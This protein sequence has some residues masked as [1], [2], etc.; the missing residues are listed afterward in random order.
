M[1]L[2]PWIDNAPR[3]ARGREVQPVTR[4]WDGRAIARI[5]LATGEDLDRAIEGAERAF[6]VMRAMPAHRRREILLAT[7]ALLRRE[8]VPLGRLMAQDAGKPVTLA[9]AE[10]DRAIATFTIAGEELRHGSGE[11]HPADIDPRGEGFVAVSQRFPVG[12]I[13]AISPFNFPLNLVAHKVAPAIAVGSAL[14]LK[15]PPQAPLVPFRLAALLAEAGLPPGGFQVLHL[16]IAVAERL[17]TDPGFAML[18]FTGSDRVGWHLKSVAGRKKV[19]LELGG[20]AATI[21]HEDAVDLPAL[22]ARVAFGAFAYAGQICIKVQRLLLHRPI[23]ARF[24]RHL[25]AATRGL[26][27]GDPLDPATIVGPMIDDEAVLRVQGWIDEAIEGG[28]RPLL[29]GRRRRRILGPTILAEVGPGMKVLSREVFGPVLTLQTYR[30]WD[31]AL[32][33]ANDSVYGLQAG[34]FTR[35]AGRV[36]AAFRELE[37]G[38]VI[39][40]DIPTLRLDHLPYGGVKASGFGR[41]GLRESMREMTESKLLLWRP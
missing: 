1:A 27:A 14:V 2:L 13:A 26:K 15:T 35:D 24:I 28:A 30:T 39:A 20:N 8:R 33:L 16:P 25:V 32:R 7:A 21:V 10:V 11:L 17:A 4:P 36:R 18:S 12:P 38:G 40:N 9:L 5:E 23:A 31:Q 6:G 22:A 19:L 37:V 34:I 29:R 3:R 41:E